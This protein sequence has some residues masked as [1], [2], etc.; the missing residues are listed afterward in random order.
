M[1]NRIIKESICTSENIENLTPEE[2][3]FFYRLLVTCDDYGRTDAREQILR[4]K[5][6]PL[7]IDR[8]SPSDIT[9]WL[10]RLCEEDLVVLYEVDGKPY[11]QMSTWEKH[12]QIRAK[13]SK[14]PA[15]DS[16]NAILISNDIN[17]NQ[18]QGYVPVIQSNPIQSES[19]SLSES[20]EQQEI[21][22][23]DDNITK[24]FEKEFGRTASPSEIELLESF[25]EDGM[26]TK[27]ICEAIKR[28]RIHGVPTVKYIKGTLNNWLAANIKTLEALELADLEYEKQ[29]ACK[30][31]PRGRPDPDKQ[32]KSKFDVLYTL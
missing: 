27:L 28:A 9:K 23:D 13:K 12:Q 17:G 24:T 5:C 26:P 1:P 30:Q 29:K 3:I 10:H 15:P 7:K 11:L 6:F 4:A 22:S 19:K 32:R 2:E 21:I 14:Y 18:M 25:E 8:I 20:K 16:D 31:N